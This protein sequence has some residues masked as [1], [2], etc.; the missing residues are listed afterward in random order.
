MRSVAV[1]GLRIGGHP[2]SPD[3]GGWGRDDI[4][5]PTGPSL[6]RLAFFSLI[7]M[8]VVDPKP[9]EAGGDREYL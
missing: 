7:A 4:A 8:N 6:Q 3:V 2:E 9:T 5:K 1:V